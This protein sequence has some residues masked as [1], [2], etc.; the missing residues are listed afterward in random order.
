MSSGRETRFDVPLKHG[1]WAG[2]HVRTMCAS[3]LLSNK[4]QR[5]NISAAYQC[6]AACV[7]VP[8]ASPNPAGGARAKSD[9]PPHP[10][11]DYVPCAC[12]SDS[13]CATHVSSFCEE[14]A[15][16]VHLPFRC[17]VAHT[18]TD[19]TRRLPVNSAAPSP[20]PPSPS[21]S[22]PPPSPPSAP[23]T[24]LRRHNTT[25]KLPPSHAADPPNCYRHRQPHRCT[26]L[27]RGSD[28][29][30]PSRF[31]PSASHSAPP[32]A[33]IVPAALHLRSRYPGCLQHLPHSYYPHL[34]VL[35]RTRPRCLDVGRSASCIPCCTSGA[36]GKA[37]AALT[38]GLQGICSWRKERLA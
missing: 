11:G 5:C 37:I 18:T 29:P 15:L 14:K 25:L 34:T 22:P 7:V 8:L 24:A 12:S 32:H 27:P 3:M 20:S 2:R 33:S 6:C 36:I 17:T 19:T 13:L 4:I 21:P 31:R 9:T 35:R 10:C 38:F 23:D 1:C 30:L 16:I 28:S 26:R